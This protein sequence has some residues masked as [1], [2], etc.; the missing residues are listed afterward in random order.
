MVTRV[1]RISLFPVSRVT[2][3]RVEG[4]AAVD[5]GDACL[6]GQTVIDISRFHFCYSCLF[7]PRA[8]I[9][10]FKTQ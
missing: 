1:M 7:Y 8:N 5:E 10:R 2:V 3:F 4:D 6:I 9:T